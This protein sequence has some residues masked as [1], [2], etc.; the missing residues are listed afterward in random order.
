MIPP[1]TAFAT[2]TALA[3]CAAAAALAALLLCAHRAYTQRADQP[4]RASSWARTAAVGVAF[5][6]TL[7]AL[8]GV[9]ATAESLTGLDHLRQLAVPMAA[10]AFYG[11]LQIMFA[12]WPQGGTGPRTS[13]RLRVVPTAAVLVLLAVQFGFSQGHGLSFAPRHAGSDRVLAYLMLY[14]VYI[15]VA[16]AE[17]TVRSAALALRAHERRQRA[18]AAGF[19][20]LAVGGLAGLVDS[21]LNIAYLIAHRLGYP[22]LA[23]AEKTLSLTVSGLC[24]LAMVAGLCIPLIGR[25]AAGRGERGPRPPA[26]TFSQ[27]SPHLP[28]PVRRIL[29]RRPGTGPARHD[30]RR[31]A[32]ARP[33]RP[34]PV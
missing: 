29:G 4:F 5:A 32:A 18:R 22:W 1:V 27:R 19:A 26:E 11:C 25:P 21:L 24:L 14:R 3:P 2:E 6:A 10:V 7:L 20:A 33:P 13:V 8:P 17:I 23:G 12:Q 31:S 16:A 28:R 34:R 30:R 9:T 15:A